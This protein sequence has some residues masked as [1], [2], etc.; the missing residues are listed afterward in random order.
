[1]Q[2]KLD[3]GLPHP[4]PLVPCPWMDAE[5]NLRVAIEDAFRMI[6]LSKEMPLFLEKQIVSQQARTKGQSQG[7][8][9]SVQVG[10]F[11]IV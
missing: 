5:E 9:L 8:F 1:M 4:C 11:T 2:T 6:L 7:G 10:E 3:V